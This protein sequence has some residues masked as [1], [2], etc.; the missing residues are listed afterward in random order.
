MYPRLASLPGTLDPPTST[1]LVLV[2]QACS[3]HLTWVVL[4]I[5]PWTPCVLWISWL[6]ELHLSPLCLVL[7]RCTLSSS[8]NGLL[9]WLIHPSWLSTGPHLHFNQIILLHTSPALLTWLFLAPVHLVRLWKQYSVA[10]S[11]PLCAQIACIS[12]SA[13]PPSESMTHISGLWQSRSSSG[14]NFLYKQSQR[15][16]ISKRRRQQFKQQRLCLPPIA[17]QGKQAGLFYCAWSLADQLSP[18][19]FLCSSRGCIWPLCAQSWSA[20]HCYSARVH[21]KWTWRMHMQLFK[22]SD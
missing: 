14:A 17:A 11:S 13:K 10:P 9:S 6:T 21:R 4:G 20:D 22:P 7:I 18:I 2:V 19:G 1:S 5:E 15:F 8:P 16:S 3:P 12:L